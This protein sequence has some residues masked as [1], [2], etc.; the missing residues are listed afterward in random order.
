MYVCVH[1]H[2]YIYIYIYIHAYK[3]LLI[4]H[5]TELTRCK[6]NLCTFINYV[7]WGWG[8]SVAPTWRNNNNNNEINNNNSNNTNHDRSNS[9]TTDND[10]SNSKPP[11]ACPMPAATGSGRPAR[12]VVVSSQ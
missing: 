5:K 11:G 2:I 1:I 9:N 6:S 8:L 4:T 7:F 12:D 10:S 3:H